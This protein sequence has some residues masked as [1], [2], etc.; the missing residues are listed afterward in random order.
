MAMSQA[1]H[2]YRVG[3]LRPSQILFSYSVGAVADLPSL[4]V[5]VMG[6]E[7][8]DDDF[9]IELAEERL[10]AAVRRELGHQ[11]KKLQAPPIPSED[12]ASPFDEAARVGIPVAPFPGWMVCPKCQRLAPLQ[13]GFFLLKTNLYRPE[14]NYYV[15][16]NC[17]KT[18]KPPRVIPVR[19]LVACEHGHLDDFPWLYFSHRGN[20]DCP[21]PL[22]LEEQGISGTAADI[23]LRCDGCNV[24]PR[25]LSDA[26]GELGKQHLPS[27]RGRHPHLR[28]FED[29]DQQMKGILLGASNSWFS[30]SLSALSIPAASGK[31]EQLVEQHWAALGKTSSLETLAVVLD[32]TQAIGQLQ[33]LKPYEVEAI[34]AAIEQKRAGGE[35]D[36]Y[37][38]LKTPEWQVFSAANPSQNTKDFQLI[39]VSPPHRYEAYF[40]QVVLIERLR[41]VRALI[42]FT[43]IQSP[44]TLPIREK[45]RESIRSKLAVSRLN[46]CQR[47]K[48]KERGF[49]SSLT[50]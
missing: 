41:E 14:R 22:R 8:W 20:T 13:S 37:Q 29:C 15:H 38:D 6:L 16:E 11:V 9:S 18:L 45:F 2:R 12:S 50:S 23:V 1:N 48:L 42:G 34:W 40:S 3:E 32:A 27:C 36:S 46:G 4:S 43:R 31:L 21:G 44:E 47:Q 25:R 28:S 39:P 26:F 5:M 10:L 30:I 33:E 24:S 49:F 7:D 17:P 19:F 35:G